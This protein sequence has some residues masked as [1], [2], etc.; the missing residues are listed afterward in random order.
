MTNMFIFDLT[1]PLNPFP[2]AV[3]LKLEGSQDVSMGDTDFV[4]L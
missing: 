1:I 3:V 4:A 2:T